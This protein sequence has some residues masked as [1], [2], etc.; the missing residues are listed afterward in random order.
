MERP[1]PAEAL[2]LVGVK[3]VPYPCRE[4]VRCHAASTGGL[5]LEIWKFI[6]MLRFCIQ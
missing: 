4:L 3:L 2:A 6:H 5:H 1:E